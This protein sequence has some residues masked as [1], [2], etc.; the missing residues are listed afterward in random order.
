[1]IKEQLA[2]LDSV[3]LAL[4]SGTGLIMSIVLALIMFG[5]ALGIKPGTLKNVFTKPRSI[6]TGLLLQW[7]GL[8]LVTF[9]LIM[10][11]NPFLTPMVSL[12]MIL[13]AC[14]PGG[15]ISN[16][17]SSYS[18]GNVELSVSMTAVSTIFA[19]ATTPF[20]FWFWGNMYLKFAA[21]SGTMTIPHL[22]IPFG[23]IFKTVFVILG[24]PIILGMLFA[25]YFPKATEK[26]K[27]PFNIFSITVFF[28]MVLGMF[29]P[30][31]HIF[32]EYIL[33]IFILVLIHNACAFLTGFGGATLMRLPKKDRRSITIEVGIQNS[34]LGLTLLLNPAIFHPEIWNNPHTG[35]MYGG[36]LFVTAWWGIWHI[37][38]GLTISSIFR[39]KKLEE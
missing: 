18:K 33:F 37:I 22:V 10:V 30:N 5:I 36:M 1:M 21:L 16:F 35:V 7:I 3:N 28:I 8:P 23:E 39:R 6:I 9:I 25:R 2:S 26:V 11:L 17:M 32:V 19:P 20:N 31:W 14:C 12:G 15:N 4:G 34:G 27:S 29:I 24:V 13:V 38:S